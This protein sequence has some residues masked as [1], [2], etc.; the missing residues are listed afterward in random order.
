MLHKVF[1]SVGAMKAGTTWLYERLRRH[2]EIHFS[3]EKEL[4]YF[5][6]KYGVGHPLSLERRKRRAAAGLAELFKNGA[7]GTDIESAV[8]WYV[9]FVGGP[10]D[11]RWFEHLIGA[12]EFADRYV[13]DFSNLT[14]HLR[15]E[16]WADL[17]RTTDTLKVIYILRD[18]IER[19]WSHY[20]YHLEFTGHPMALRPAERI[21]P[22]KRMLEKDWF[23]RNSY[24]STVIGTL[25]AA[26]PSDDYLI[27]YFED[28][29]TQP[30]RF[31]A[32][33]EEF[34][35]IGSIE[36]DPQALFEK[37]NASTEAI[38]PPGWSRHAAAVLR[39]EIAWLKE[40]GFWHP[41]WK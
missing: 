19:V 38:M 16:D 26:L 25:T 41:A 1:L 28:M 14:C 39:D 7:A 6:E 8:R 32:K 5:A 15:K 34:L 9:D 2:S 30:A 35:G 36:H 18:P 29:I 31:L 10:V 12:E 3:M 22:F 23:I 24:Y 20:K 4:H 37:E 17:L 13:A 40:H 27:C 21:L 11:D 33:V